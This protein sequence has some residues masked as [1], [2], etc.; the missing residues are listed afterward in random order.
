MIAP[1]LGGAKGHEGACPQNYF[2]TSIVAMAPASV[3]PRPML[4]LPPPIIALGASYSSR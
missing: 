3:R 1:R 2:E 4:R